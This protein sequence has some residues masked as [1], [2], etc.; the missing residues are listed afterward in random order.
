MRI[1]TK[2]LTLE[3]CGLRYKV[4]PYLSYLYIKFHGTING[5]PFEIQAEFL[6][7]LH[8][9]LNLRLG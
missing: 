5:D 8:T 1:V 2:W 4:A 9:K 6:I 3:L 7:S